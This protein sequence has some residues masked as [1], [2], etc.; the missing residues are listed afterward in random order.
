[1]YEGKTGEVPDRKHVVAADDVAPYALVRGCGAERRYE[2][3]R[4]CA[5]VPRRSDLDCRHGLAYGVNNLPGNMGHPARHIQ[6]VLF[7]MVSEYPRG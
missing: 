5:M 4:D 2:V 3:A 6:L 7:V 1:M